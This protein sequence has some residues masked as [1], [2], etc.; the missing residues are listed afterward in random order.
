MST[1]FCVTKINH[2]EGTG[3]ILGTWT[4]GTRAGAEAFA[5]ENNAAAG[6]HP[7]EFKVVELS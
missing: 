6:D 4:F 5:A 7:V 2:R 1:F 3:E